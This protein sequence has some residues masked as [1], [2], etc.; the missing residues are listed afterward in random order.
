MAELMGFGTDEKYDQKH[1]CY[2]YFI[3]QTIY[4]NMNQ[5]LLKEPVKVLS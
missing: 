5:E 1:D 4:I 2:R 3:I